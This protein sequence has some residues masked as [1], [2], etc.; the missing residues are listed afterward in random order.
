[1]HANATSL[2]S[3]TEHGLEAPTPA[4]A[5]EPDAAAVEARRV[6]TEVSVA[7]VKELLTI[8]ASYPS[9]LLYDGDAS[10]FTVEATEGDVSMSEQS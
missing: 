2:N 9:K 1:M 3:I 4:Q 5:S 7:S 6:Q 8:L 10:A